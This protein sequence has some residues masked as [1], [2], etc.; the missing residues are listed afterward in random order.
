MAEESNNNSSV[1]THIGHSLST[2]GHVVS[3]YNRALGETIAVIGDTVEGLGD[4]YHESGST[5]PT[6]SQLE[7]VIGAFLGSYGAES[8]VTSVLGETALAT[9]ALGLSIL[10]LPAEAAGGAAVVTVAGAYLAAGYVG[11]KLG[12]LLEETAV[13]ALADTRNPLVDPDNNVVSNA[14]R[15]AQTLNPA[16]FASDVS[17][18]ASFAT[19]GSTTGVVGGLSPY[20]VG[21][22]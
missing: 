10:G 12:E 16:G 15:I 8:V 13:N 14:Q 18:P 11:A 5:E 6:H 1:G 21:G 7:K 17:D 22:E 20:G 2:F 4:A 9:T 19:A 3:S